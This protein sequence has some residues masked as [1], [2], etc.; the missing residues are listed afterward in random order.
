MLGI[1]SF[2]DLQTD[3]FNST[4][5]D[6]M[7]MLRVRAWEVPD[8]EN[9]WSEQVSQWLTDSQHD[10]NAMIGIENNITPI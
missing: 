8:D 3:I 9:R 1:V 5:L 10:L 2:A 7:K 6:A 4:A